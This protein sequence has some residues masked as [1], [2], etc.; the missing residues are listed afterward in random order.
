MNSN[1]H[2]L[3]PSNYATESLIPVKRKPNST[4]ILLPLSSK[5]PSSGLLQYTSVLVN[6]TAITNHPDTFMAYSNRHVFP[7]M[8]LGEAWKCAPGCGSSS[9]LFAFRDPG[10]SSHGKE[11][12]RAKKNCAIWFKDLTRSCLHT[13]HW[14][15]AGC[16]AQAWPLGRWWTGGRG[17]TLGYSCSLAQHTKWQESKN[18]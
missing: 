13:F 10:W 3:Q 4:K 1:T 16:M 12:Q 5:P 7:T 15:N 6:R 8:W 17:E 14:T 9:H 2:V 18:V 11:S